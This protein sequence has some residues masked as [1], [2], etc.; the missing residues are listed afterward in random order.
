MARKR[1]LRKTGLLTQEAE[2]QETPVPQ[3]TPVS[4]EPVEVVEKPEKK[5]L[6]SNLLPGKQ[7]SE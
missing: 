5:S 2:V 7:E 4:V 3:P 1:K 6:L